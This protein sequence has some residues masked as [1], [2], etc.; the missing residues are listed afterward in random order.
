MP[1]FSLCP[2]PLTR[3]VDPRLGCEA[4]CEHGREEDA[5]S[6][7]TAQLRCTKAA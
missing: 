1:V 2:V 7:W 6:D 5:R 3:L 4:R